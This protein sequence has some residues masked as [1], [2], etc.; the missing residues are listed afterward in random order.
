MA[1]ISMVFWISRTGAIEAASRCHAKD[2]DTGGLI[3]VVLP[4][5]LEAVG[6]HLRSGRESPGMTSGNWKSRHY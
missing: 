6:M 4:G 2:A 5:Y 3:Y 1:T